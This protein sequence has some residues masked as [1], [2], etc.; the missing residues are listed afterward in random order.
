MRAYQ[1][2]ATMTPEH[3]TAFFG[4]LA[5]QS[6]GSFQQ[7]VGAAAAALNSR[8]QYLMKQPLEKRAA[9]VRRSLSRVAADV[10]AEEML[11]SYFL[12]CR[13]PLL[14]EWLD[15]T[16]VKHEDGVLE[17][18]EPPEPSARKLGAAVKK[19]RSADED[20]DRPLLLKAFAAQSAI[21]WP[22]LEALLE[23]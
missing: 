2:F 16:G 17:E 18:D 7:A 5:E 10:V 15:A 23:G 9:A 19:F 4:R 6:P 3:A 12:E 21:D 14:V 11:A 13:K 22:R 8:P 20:P 1:I